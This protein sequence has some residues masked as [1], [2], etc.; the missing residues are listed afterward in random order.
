MTHEERSNTGT[1]LAIIIGLLLCLLLVVGGGIGVVFVMR[2][3]AYAAQ[4]QAER[5]RE[6]AMADRLLYERTVVA[7]QAIPASAQAKNIEIVIDTSGE[8]RIEGETFTGEELAVH[9]QQQVSVD[10]DAVSVTLRVVDDTAY[11][12]LN[13][14]TALCEK[15]GVKNIS[16]AKAEESDE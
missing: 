11:L 6:R 16:L 1:T 12:L 15:A 10:P 9:L 4:L 14:V 3:R 5:D 2:D 13:G 7:A 8:Y